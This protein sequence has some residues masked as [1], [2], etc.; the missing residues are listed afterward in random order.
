MASRYRQTR[1]LSFVSDVQYIEQEMT[2]MSS[3]A[4]FEW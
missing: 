4:D 2:T 1:L 3:G